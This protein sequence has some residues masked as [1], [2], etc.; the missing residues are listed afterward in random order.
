MIQ[1]QNLTYSYPGTEKQVLKD[2]SF[3]IKEG[4][5]F[6]FL[7][8]SGAGKS[9]T[10][11]VLNG[12]LK[13]FG[14]SVHINGTDLSKM[15]RSFYEKIGVAF[16]FPNL[17]LKL[18]ALENLQL[19]ASFFKS[20]TRDPDELLKMVQLEGDRDTRVEA[21]SKGMKMRLSFIRSLLNQPELLFLDEPTAG[22]DPGNAR[23]MKDIILD[24]K[25]QGVTIFL[26]THHMD[27]AG[28]LCNRLAFMVEGTLPVIDSTQ[29][30]RLK[31]GKKT[32]RLE[33][34]ENGMTLSDEFP[35]DQLAFNPTF[36]EILENQEIL[37][38]HTQEAS[39]EDIFIKVTGQQ[40]KQ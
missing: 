8:P 9:T 18:T 19:F 3:E 17:Y 2:I 5:I 33:Y 26:T 40:L 24:L 36:N 16:E 35:I 14:G 7:G 34:M 11:K 12:L 29:E 38:I 32:V 22:L 21:F 31:H 20:K 13:G 6:G 39:L 30:L 1:V 15:K 23:I 28:E 4:E 27:D 37:T 25:Q 10:Q